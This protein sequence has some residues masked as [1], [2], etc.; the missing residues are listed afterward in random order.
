MH[1]GTRHSTIIHYMTL[2]SAAARHCRTTLWH[3]RLYLTFY[4][5]ACA[6]LYDIISPD[7][8]H[9]IT[10]FLEGTGLRTG[11]LI[12]SNYSF[13]AAFTADLCRLSVQ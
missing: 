1:Y 3:L 11:S 8:H 4:A 7:A 6:S 12:L 10:S 2:H 13:G 9:Y 5:C